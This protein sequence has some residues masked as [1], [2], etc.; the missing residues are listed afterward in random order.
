V[1]L[2]E[3]LEHYRAAGLGVAVLTYDAPEAQQ[4][5]VV[6][7]GIGY[8]MLSDV[9]AATVNALGILNTEYEP[10][11]PA[12]GIPHPGIFILDGDLVIRG[13]L[14]VEGYQTRVDAQEVLAVARD[15]LGLR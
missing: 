5:F 4:Q 13:K 6:S 14:F 15:T 10:G 2:Q 8:P 9:D 7:R 11:H 1:Q 3:H 12:Y